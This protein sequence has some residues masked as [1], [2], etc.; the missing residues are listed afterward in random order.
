M[1]KFLFDG[2]QIQGRRAQTII[3]G[4]LP[5]VAKRRFRELSHEEVAARFTLADGHPLDGCQGRITEQ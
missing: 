2:N 5:Y 4:G 3:H 1:T